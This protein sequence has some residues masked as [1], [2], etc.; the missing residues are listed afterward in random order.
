M[1]FNV[2]LFLAQNHLN[3]ISNLL[4]SLL[5]LFGVNIEP[6]AFIFLIEHNGLMS[7]IDQILLFH[8][9]QNFMIKP[10]SLER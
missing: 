4:N 6:N 1:N 5:N 7:F 9:L 10:L 8:A 2:L 3:L